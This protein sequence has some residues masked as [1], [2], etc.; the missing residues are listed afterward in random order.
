MALLRMD[1][2]THLEW[3]PSRMHTIPSEHDPKWIRLRLDTIPNG[4]E[5]YGHDPKWTR[6]R[7]D[8]ILNGHN[9]Q[10]DTI[11]NGHDPNL[12]LT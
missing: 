11:L 2:K 5:P 4:Q 10:M 1:E 9:S 12:I 3:A 7:M 6:F 8:T